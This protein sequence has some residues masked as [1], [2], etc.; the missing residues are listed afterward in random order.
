MS[1]TLGGYDASRLKSHDISFT[2]PQADGIPSAFVRGLEVTTDEGQTTSDDWD[3]DTQILTEWNNSFTAKID[4]STPYLWLPDSVCDR[5]AEALG[6][7]YNDTFDLYTVTDDQYQTYS[8]EKAF[9]FTFTFS[10]I[11]NS[12]D[13][14]SPL[15]VPGVVNITI[16]SRAFISLLGYPFMDDAIEYGDPAVP[17]FSL[18]R[19]QNSSFIIGRSFLQESYLITKYDEGVFSLHEALFSETPDL[20]TIKRPDNSP[21][22]G[23]PAVDHKFTTA[24]M[25]GIAVAVVIFV[26]LVLMAGWYVWRRKKR[27]SSDSVAVLEANKD[28]TSSLSPDTP[29]TPISRILSKIA[30]RKR[31]RKP[32]EEEKQQPSEAPDSEI[33]EL[34]A[35]VPPAELDGGGDDH[36]DNGETELGLENTQTSSAYEQAR[37]KLDRQLRGPVPEYTPPASGAL[38]PPEKTFHDMGP[39][40]SRRTFEQPSP[41]S[42]PTRSPHGADGDSNSLPMSLPSPLSPTGDD[43]SRWEEGSSSNTGSAPRLPYPIITTTS[44]GPKLALPMSATSGAT[45][46]SRSNSDNSVS[47]ISPQSVS[48]PSSSGALQRTPIDPSKVVCLGPLPENVQLPIHNSPPRL[49]ADLR[50]LHLPDTKSSSHRSTD[51]LGS[52][53]TDD[54]ERMVQEMTRQQRSQS[55]NGTDRNGRRRPQPSLQTQG[56]AIRRHQSDRTA[57]PDTPHSQERID[58]GTELI[59]VPQMA[60]KRYSWEESSL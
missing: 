41:V 1:T 33:Y 48:L 27:S 51:S 14:G 57:D 47:P 54:E 42:S 44:S 58:S 34:P 53:F 19:A 37:R 21:Y 60:A 30:R 2:L 43:A 22:P 50:N 9:S 31:S 35:P 13:F 23:P 7:H 12:D 18:R 49:P 16:P 28:S 39:A 46:M 45:P 25:A 10:S 3:S 55:V 24:Q 26:V 11:D 5:F 40:D 56:H 29:R 4:S 17:Y 59:H 38:P 52:N 32:I 6:L 15:D 8:Q 36:S 20:I